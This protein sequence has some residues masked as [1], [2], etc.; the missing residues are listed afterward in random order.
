M[1]TQVVPAPYQAASAPL[2]GYQLPSDD[3]YALPPQWTDDFVQQLP[4]RTEDDND[5]GNYEYESAFAPVYR[6]GVYADEIYAPVSQR[7]SFY[8]R[9]LL[10]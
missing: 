1:D 7:N 5:Y 2:T 8:S 10:R 4:E 3:V 6:P 9:I